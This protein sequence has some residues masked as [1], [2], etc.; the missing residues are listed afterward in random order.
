MQE[1]LTGCAHHSISPRKTVFLNESILQF[2][3]WFLSPSTFHMSAPKLLLVL[4]QKK[5]PTYSHEVWTLHVRLHFFL[6]MS[7][8]ISKPNT[9]SR[10]MIIQ[11]EIKYS[12]HFNNNKLLIK[13][14]P[15]E[16]NGIHLQRN[17]TKVKCILCFALH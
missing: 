15:F 9:P 6:S 8:A 1:F 11:R 12:W 3:C 2:L 14:T 7:G 13:F 5:Y 10:E 16:R 4:I 17:W